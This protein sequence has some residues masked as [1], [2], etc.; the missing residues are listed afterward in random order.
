MI[1]TVCSEAGPL[2]S[3]PASLL[4]FG[5]LFVC[6]FLTQLKSDSFLPILLFP[7]CIPSFSC[8]A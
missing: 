8:M 5:V 2:N 3:E 1:N 4:W 7:F 6:L